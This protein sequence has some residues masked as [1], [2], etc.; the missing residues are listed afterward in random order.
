MN[1]IEKIAELFS[2]IFLIA[3]GLLGVFVSILDFSGADFENGPWKWLKGPL[4]ITL[5]TIAIL[6]IA[7]GLER[8]VRFRKIDNQIAKI[9][10][11]LERSVGGRY[12]EGTNELF[13]TASR[14]LSDTKDHIRTTHLVLS[15]H[16]PQSYMKTFIEVLKQSKVRGKP[17]RVDI[18]Y[19]AD[20]SKSSQSIHLVVDWLRGQLVNAGVDDLVQVYATNIAWS[21]ADFLIIDDQHLIIAF[22]TVR[23]IKQLRIG[24]VFVNQPKIVSDIAAWY[25]D[26]LVKK[27]IAYQHFC[28][29]YPV[30]NEAS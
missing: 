21:T 5:L 29:Q 27:A 14:L 24:L 13:D 15:H 3:A 25:D 12:L 4:P 28:K 6:A 9:E 20:F 16:A 8:F 1:K 26:V 11:A 19:G 17:I 10:K 22:P 23:G 18:V 2:I 7:I 30:Q